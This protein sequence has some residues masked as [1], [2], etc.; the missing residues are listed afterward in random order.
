[1]S[2]DDKLKLALEL[3]DAKFQEYYQWLSKAMAGSFFDEVKEEL[4]TLIT[5]NLIDFELRQ[6]FTE[7]HLKRLAVVLCLDTTNADLKILQ[8]F[9]SVGIK[10]YITFVSKIPLPGLESHLRVALIYFTEAIETVDKPFDEANKEK[11]KTL[12]Q[13]INPGLLD[14]E[15]KRLI[16]GINTRFLNSLKMD[17]L[18]KTFSMFMR[19]KNRDTCQYEVVLNKDW[20]E[21]SLPS[22]QIVLAW[23]NTPKFDFLYHIAHII[24]HHGLTMTRVN[25]TYIDPYSRET[26]LLMALGLDGAKGEAAWD[27]ADVDDFLKEL[28][29]AKYFSF[30][31]EISQVFVANRIL[32]GNQAN[33]VRSM[34]S[35]I[36][37]SLTL[38][39][40]HLFSFQNC[41]EA[42]LR[43][44]ELT[45]M[46]VD[47][48]V[49]KF[50]PKNVDLII[51][52][53]IKRELI[54]LIERLDT[55][56]EINDHRR[57]NVFKQGVNFIEN[58]VKTNYYQKNKTAHSFRLLPEYLDHIPFDRKQRF[59]ELPY[60]LFFITNKHFVSFHI[61]FHDLAR[62]G[63]RTIFPEHHERATAERNAVF[64]ECY[65]LAYTQNKKNKD[66]PEG[67][68]KAVIL[69]LPFDR[70]AVELPILTKELQIGG[71]SKEEIETKLLKYN[72]EQRLE[73][74]YSNQRSFIRNLVVL[75]N[76]DAE[77]KLRATNI[78][79]YWKKPEYL[80][81]GP[82]ENMHDSMI[83]WIASYSVLEGY[84]PGPAFISGKPGSGINHK[85]YGVTSL[86]VN[87]YMEEVLKY[88]GID[89]STTPF[90][91]KIVGGPDGDVAGNQICNLYKYYFDTAKVLAL[92]DIS[93]TINDPQGLDLKELKKLFDEKNPIRFY[94]AEKLSEGGFLLD[95]ETYREESSYSHQTL[96]KRM[97][98]DHLVDDWLSGNEMNTLF[99]TNVHSVKSDI[100]IPAGGRP[101]TLNDSNY[102]ELLDEAGRPTTKAII[103]GANLYLTPAARSKL[104]DLGVLI[105]KD[106]SA[107]K[108]GVICSSFE[109]LFGLALKDDELIKVKTILVEEILQILKDKARDE[110][111]LLLRTHKENGERLTKISDEIS[112]RINHYFDELLEHFETQPLP[113][114]DDDPLIKAFLDYCPRLLREQYRLELLKKIPENH[115]KAI[116]ACYISSKLVYQKG[117]SWSPSLID[118]L[119]L[120]LSD[121][122]LQ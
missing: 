6:Y 41:E 44:P 77:D 2:D 88:L 81:L 15:F 22:L 103:E 42:L 7:I 62:G 9:R 96:C 117:L 69:L 30:F 111:H 37:Q 70:T 98:Q 38:V 87:I 104:E 39:D 106:S 102:E 29:T 116:I 32:S 99:R 79:D 53:K 31:D 63:V 19:A 64:T 89:P 71:L 83:S 54:S 1:M 82:D 74:L 91:I 66:I 48:F 23:K 57:K 20:K 118:I 90:T 36:H 27:A 26:M 14:K 50:H 25:A 47:V 84:K 110:A 21:K 61:R 115:K 8:N 5:R 107:N 10:N 121:L 92:T 59:E 72:E 114:E 78:I 35:F 13:E 93:G 17:L 113:L 49:A 97:L 3:E 45:K 40:M 18:V 60:G 16:T 76:C 24:H 95:R 12:V 68:A 120:V 80:Y 73:Y 28:V 101:R 43:H 11:L 4:L 55:G 51:Y 109:V 52:N 105:I 108:T 119:P 34:L 67:G 100:F 112:L 122:N 46:L 94:P 75:V 65:N 58:T 85:E 56:N 33:F 86:G